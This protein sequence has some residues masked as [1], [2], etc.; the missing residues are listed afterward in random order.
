[1]GMGPRLA[2]GAPLVLQLEGLPYKSLTPVYVAVALA[3][4]IVGVAVWFIVFPGPIRSDGGATAC[5]ARAT[6]EGTGGARGP[7]RGAPG[8]PHRRGALHGPACRRSWHSSNASMASSTWR[9]PPGPAGRASPRERR[10]RPADPVRRL[11]TFRPPPRAL[12]RVVLLRGR[13]YLRAARTERR[14]QVHAPL[15]PGHAAASE[16]R[17]RAIRRPLR[18]AMAA[19]GPRPRRAARARAAV[20][21]GADGRREP[22]VLR[23]VIRAAR[24]RRPRRARRL[25]Q[26]ALADRAD[27][28]V[29][30]FSRGMRQRL[31]LERALLHAPRLLLLDEP[32]TGLDEASAA[33]LVA[34]VARARSG[35]RDDRHGDSRSRSG[36][37]PAHARR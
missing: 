26:A 27:D 5:P 16:L 23:T 25:G 33:A 21:S 4:A 18:A 35:R 30:G 31:A 19:P 10:L 20:V 14:R 11:P 7:R 17:R 12:A 22:A 6:R 15:H 13:R 24:R 1:M 3:T 8:R 9:A 28:P 2:A 32:F 29:S 34:P 36:R 37:R